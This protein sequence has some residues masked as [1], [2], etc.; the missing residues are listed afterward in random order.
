MDD[1]LEAQALEQGLEQTLTDNLLSFV[2]EAGLSI[3]E[4]LLDGQEDCGRVVAPD[5][6]AP[7]AVAIFEV[8]I[9]EEAPVLEV[10]AGVRG[11]VEHAPELV[12]LV[13]AVPPRPRE[14]PEGLQIGATGIATAEADDSRDDLDTG[15]PRGTASLR[16]SLFEQD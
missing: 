4:L 6:I 1:R 13:Q 15:N 12:E 2:L 8:V 9:G 11:G 7:Q 10:F 5:P 16:L 3:L 14:A